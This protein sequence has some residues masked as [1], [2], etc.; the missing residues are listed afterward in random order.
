MSLRKRGFVLDLVPN[1][2]VTPVFITQT[3]GDTRPDFGYAPEKLIDGSGLSSTPTAENWASVAH[4]WVGGAA[5]GATKA[6]GN[7]HYF[8]QQRQSAA[9]VRV[10]PRRQPQVDRIGDLGYRRP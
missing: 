5:A 2:L 9:A 6:Q 7:P 10:G 4:P 3:Q 1:V 8:Q